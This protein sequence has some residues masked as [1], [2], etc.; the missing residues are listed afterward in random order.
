[1][2]CKWIML[3]QLLLFIM[4]FPF[5]FR[6]LSSNKPT[7]DKQLIE[8]ISKKEISG[9][10]QES[11]YEPMVDLTH[12]TR[13]IRFLME[14]G[15]TDFV[16][17]SHDAEEAEKLRDNLSPARLAFDMDVIDDEYPL[18][19]ACFYREQSQ[20]KPFLTQLQEL[21]RQKEDIKFVLV[22]GDKLFSLVEW[23]A[24]Q[25]FPTLLFVKDGEIVDHLDDATIEQVR[26][27]INNLEAKQP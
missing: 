9:L 19:V 27:K 21:A 5:L 22:D 4:S 13:L 16:F 14:N 6:Y 15:H 11:P 3:S 25:T 8:S 23:A 2:K 24:I 7:H 1:M 12:K 18:V 20:Y 10:L 26:P 17:E